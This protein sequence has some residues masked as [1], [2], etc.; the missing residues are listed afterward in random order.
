VSGC[1]AT[2]LGKS[3]PNFEQ[4]LHA[5]PSLVQPKTGPL[6]EQVEEYVV[7][8]KADLVVMGSMAL[9]GPSNQVRG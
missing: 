8:N 7:A 3:S 6:V 5:L 2:T 1:R 9:G 4:K